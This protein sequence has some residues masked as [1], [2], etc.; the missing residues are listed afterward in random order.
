[1]RLKFTVSFPF[2]YAPESINMGIFSHA[3]D[4]WS[5][6]VTLWETYSFGQ[7]PYGDM[8]GSEVNST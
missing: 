2:R 6:G 5:Y 3:S 1:M 7:Q 8:S 4:A